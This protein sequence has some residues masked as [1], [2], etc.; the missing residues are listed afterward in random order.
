VLRFTPALWRYKWL[1]PS[2][3]LAGFGAGWSAIP[4]VEPRY[5]A[6]ATLLVRAVEASSTLPIR[7]EKLPLSSR[8]LQELLKTNRV[9]APVV[10]EFH[11]AHGSDAQSEREAVESVAERLRLR[12]RQDDSGDLLSVVLV[13]SA[14]EQTA[15]V[16]NAVVERFVS[17][18]VDLK[19]EKLSTLASILQQQ[20]VRAQQRLREAEEE[21]LSVSACNIRRLYPGCPMAWL[22]PFSRSTG[23]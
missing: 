14:P 16:L 12:V 8:S 4:L 15:T 9:L 19:N 18:A 17:A 10:Q 21:S 13:G 11:L 5:E 22:I 7:P 3:T 1:I 2:I 23:A 20:R 6:R